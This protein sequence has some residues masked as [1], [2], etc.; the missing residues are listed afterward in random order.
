[1]IPIHTYKGRRVAVF[2]LGRTGIAAA[3][4]LE[5]GGAVVSSWDDSETARA[6]AEAAGVHLD[7]LNRRDWGDIAALVLSPGIPLTHPKPHR[8]VE[9]AQSAAQRIV[10]G[11]LED[12]GKCERRRPDSLDAA[13]PPPCAPNSFRLR[14]ISS[15][16]VM[17]PN[18]L[19]T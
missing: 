19:V 4:A 2:G 10:D 13:S 15:T 5:A 12:Y 7:D 11:V 16:L 9:L 8:M 18:S 1:M 14:C 3:K 6:N 17:K